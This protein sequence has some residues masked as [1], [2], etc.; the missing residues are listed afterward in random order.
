LRAP[1]SNLDRSSPES[2]GDRFVALLLA[3][4]AALSVKMLTC[5]LR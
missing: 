1:R 3:M 4:T 2:A 5:C